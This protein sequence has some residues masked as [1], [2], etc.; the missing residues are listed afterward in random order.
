MVTATKVTLADADRL[1]HKI[2]ICLD[3]RSSLLTLGIVKASFTLLSLNRS[4]VKGLTGNLRNE[5]PRS[6]EYR[7]VINRKNTN[8]EPFAPNDREL[9]A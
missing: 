5:V 9:A 3:L 7:P 1:F 4:L 8:L 2:S 6:Y